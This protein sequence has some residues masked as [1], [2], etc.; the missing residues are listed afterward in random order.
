M[1]EYISIWYAS[2]L[3]EWQHVLKQAWTPQVAKLTLSQHDLTVFYNV[4]CCV[5]EC[6]AFSSFKCHHT[7]SGQF[8]YRWFLMVWSHVG[9]KNFL[10]TKK[11]AKE[12]WLSL[13]F[14]HNCL[15][16]APLNIYG[17]CKKNKYKDKKQVKEEKLEYNMIVLECETNQHRICKRFTVCSIKIFQT[18]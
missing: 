8:M 15:N 4:S 13:T 16:S 5:T 1:S 18:C 17:H 3:L 2:L 7:Y 14:L 12:S 9:Y 6:L 11:R 10:N